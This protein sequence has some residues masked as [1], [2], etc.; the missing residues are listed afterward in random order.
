MWTI[1]YNEQGNMQ[2]VIGKHKTVVNDSLILCVEIN[3]MTKPLLST[4]FITQRS[5]VEPLSLVP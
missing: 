5:F 4:N 1:T 2:L 3:W